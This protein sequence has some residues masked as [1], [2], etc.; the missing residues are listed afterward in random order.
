MLRCVAVSSIPSCIPSSVMTSKVLV[1]FDAYVATHL[2]C[3]VLRIRCMFSVQ[4]DVPAGVSQKGVTQV[5]RGGGNAPQISLV[6][7][8]L[9]GGVVPVHNPSHGGRVHHGTSGAEYAHVVHRHAVRVVVRVAEA[10]RVSFVFCATHRQQARAAQAKNQR[11]IS[12][13]AAA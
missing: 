11:T 3:I 12:R 5:S 7:D 4:L 2:R 10:G 9:A 1:H 13:V 8:V 6:F